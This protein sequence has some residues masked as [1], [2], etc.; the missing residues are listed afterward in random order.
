MDPIAKTNLF[1]TSYE[2]LNLP[3]LKLISPSTTIEA[4]L[5]LFNANK[6]IGIVKHSDRNA[7][8]GIIAIMDVT[9]YMI[10]KLK[11]N[12]NC[13]N[14]PIEWVLTLSPEHESYIVWERDIHDSMQ[15]V[16]FILF[17]PW[18]HLRADCT[19]G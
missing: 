10:P 7:I 4:T 5:E 8:L 15:D 16:K 6:H 11:L 12:Q 17:R 1:E 9:R 13:L 18:R 14:D 3:P 2:K 19:T